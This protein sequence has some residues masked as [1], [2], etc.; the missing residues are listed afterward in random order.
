M[1]LDTYLLL[2]ILA[3]AKKGNEICTLLKLQEQAKVFDGLRPTGSRLRLLCTHKVRGI[4]DMGTQTWPST[5][6]L[7]FCD[8]DSPHQ[9]LVAS[10]LFTIH[11]MFASSSTWPAIVNKVA[12][13]INQ[14]M[15][16]I[17]QFRSSSTIW[18]HYF[19]DCYCY[20]VT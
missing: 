3:I 18:L 20:N 6:G 14:L 16:V 1:G 19:L 9:W 4:L 10:I 11:P 5:S 12:L 8:D 2:D 15:A 17:T 13:G 7:V